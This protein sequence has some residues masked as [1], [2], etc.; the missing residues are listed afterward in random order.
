MGWEDKGGHEKYLHK[1]KADDSA[2][3]TM[4]PITNNNGA[5]K[6]IK[7]IVDANAR[8]CIEKMLMPFLTTVSK[9]SLL[10][11]VKGKF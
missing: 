5:Y 1:V 2:N 8:Y 7:S 11:K 9:L 4:K 6:R 3:D 10:E